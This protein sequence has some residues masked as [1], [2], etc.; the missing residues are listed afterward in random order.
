MKNVI[1]FD[2][3]CHL[4]NGAIDFVLRRDSKRYFQVASLQG[5]T[6]EQLLQPEAR[7]SLESI[8]LYQ[9][10]KLLKKSQ[11]ILVILSHL[12]LFERCMALVG[13]V[14]PTKLADVL[15]EFVARNRYK[16][17]GVRETCRLPTPEERS[18]MLE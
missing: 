11:A 18:R 17:F 7:K 3:V 13:R 6:A 2:G 15:Y 10:G 8:I 1:F 9:D 12:G 16:W 5:K 14:L 4:C